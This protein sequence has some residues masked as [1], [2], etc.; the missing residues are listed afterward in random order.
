M[1]QRIL[2]EKKSA[3]KIYKSTCVMLLKTNMFLNRIENEKFV[4]ISC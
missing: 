2:T 4:P 3:V 1:Y